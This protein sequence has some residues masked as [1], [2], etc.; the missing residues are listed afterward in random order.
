M[1]VCAGRCNVPRH[2]SQFPLR[3]PST[4]QRMPEI[5]DFIDHTIEKRVSAGL[6]ASHIGVPVLGRVIRLATHL[7]E[8][9][10]KRYAEL[11]LTMMRHEILLNLFIQGAPYQL[12]PGDIANVTFM[13]TGGVSK[14]LEELE[15]AGYVQRIADPSDR[16]RVVVRLTGEGRELIEQVQPDIVALQRQVV[17]ALAEDEIDT[18]N[19]LLRK[20]LLSVERQTEVIQKR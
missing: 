7:Q 19:K 20:L 13:S 11:G 18:L 15:R 17:E 16:R 14:A 5:K 10:H 4:M 6:P 3:K 2:L 9:G 1:L 8:L 12:S